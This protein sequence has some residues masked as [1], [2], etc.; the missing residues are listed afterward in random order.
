MAKGLSNIA[1]GQWA[2]GVCLDGVECFL[3]LELVEGIQIGNYFRRVYFL[4]FGVEKK[5]CCAAEL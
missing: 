5:L 1:Q 3:V 2:V 4:I